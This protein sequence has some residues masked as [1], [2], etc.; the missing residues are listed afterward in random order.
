MDTEDFNSH[1]V[2]SEMCAICGS[3]VEHENGGIRTNHRGNTINLCGPGCLE[4]F[5]GEPDLFLARF[6]EAMRE[7][8]ARDENVL[9]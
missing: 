4:T 3:P 5:A 1:Q 7:R 8:T 9:A 2:G 6:A